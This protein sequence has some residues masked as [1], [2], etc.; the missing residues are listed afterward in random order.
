MP[1]VYCS[2]CGTLAESLDPFCRKCGARMDSTQ[3]F[4]KQAQQAIPDHDIYEQVAKS[5]DSP[6]LPVR[7]ACLITA[8]LLLATI[9]L[10]GVFFVFL[11]RQPDARPLLSIEFLGTATPYP[12]Q[13][14]YLTAAVYATARPYPSATIY[15]SALPYATS[16]PVAVFVQA[17]LTSNHQIPRKYNPMANCE[18]RI[19]NQNKNEDAVILLVEE[20]TTISTAAVYIRANDSINKTGIPSGTYHTYITLGRDWDSLN[21]RFLTD[22]FY[23]RFKDPTTLTTCSA[24]YSSSHEYLE[25]TLYI[26][27]GTGTEAEMVDPN[28]FPSISP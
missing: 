23:F 9:C 2:K 19:K 16:G 11:L 1:G 13:R 28:D 18:L 10:V 6:V 25:I 8:G 14:P 3:V 5:P 22:P 15:P 20:G 21:G 24:G 26:T 4:E 17:D 12:T 7:T 27:Q